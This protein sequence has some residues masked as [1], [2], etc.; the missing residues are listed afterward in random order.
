VLRYFLAAAL[1]VATGAA[2]PSVVIALEGEPLEF[3]LRGSGILPRLNNPNF[4]AIFQISVD[5]PGVPL[6][7]GSY[8]MDTGVMVF[9]PRFPL[10][11]GVTYRVRYKL[12]NESAEKT[13]TIPKPV[14]ESTTVVERVFPSVST[15]PENQLKLYIHFSAAMSK[16]E[17]F[18]RIRLVEDGGSDVKLPFLELDEELWDR[19][20]KR[21]TVLF[22]PGRIKRDL[23]PNREVGP[24]LKE[25]HKYTLVIDKSWI[26][27][28]GA[29]LKAE[30]RKE[31][32]VG[33]PD[34]TPLDTNTW[35]VTPPSA[36]SSDPVVLD[37]PEPIDA[38]LLQ[39]FID[40]V[41]QKGDLVEGKVT[42]DRDE[43]RW[44]FTPDQAWAAG[45][46]KLEIVS[47]LED[48]AGNKVG[49]AFDVDVFD[50]VQRQLTSE[51]FSVPFTIAPK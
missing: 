6:L 13:F 10:T 20:F 51:S 36:A 18:K 21:L 50:Q 14:V 32:S 19:E 28:K 17:A 16:G 24:P 44:S 29:P 3:R 1:V 30:Y 39:R 35:Q 43:M 5:Q 45:S 25:G 48:L 33:P 7:A 41:N 4:Q 26:D 38:A 2:Q 27:A 12:A 22:D 37:F 15:L 42:V 23:V 31:F 11:P 34:R 46:Y 40:V 49:K 8:K 9:T 47:T